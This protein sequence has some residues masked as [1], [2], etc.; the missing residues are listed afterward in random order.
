M[1][2]A[3]AMAAAVVPLG[4]WRGGPAIAGVVAISM[5]SVVVV[6]SLLGT[7]LP[8]LLHRMRLDPATASG[9]LVTSMADVLGV[10]IY[11][12]VASRLLPQP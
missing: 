4:L 9:P 10:I 12:S 11:F 5:L 8:I 1:S 3:L 2:A 7:L 6:G